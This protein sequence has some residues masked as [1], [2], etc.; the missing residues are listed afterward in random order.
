V[1]LISQRL[2]RGPVD[3]GV[4]VFPEVFGVADGRSESTDGRSKPGVGWGLTSG[5]FDD[6]R[7]MFIE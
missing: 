6:D 3:S 5:E 7:C 2:E 4:G 1:V